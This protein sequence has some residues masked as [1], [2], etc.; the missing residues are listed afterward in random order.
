MPYLCLLA[1][2]LDV[3]PALLV[4]AVVCAVR[5]PGLAGPEEVQDLDPVCEPLVR[6]GVEVVRVGRDV[7]DERQPFRVRRPVREVR[8]QQP[9]VASWWVA[10]VVQEKVRVSDGTRGYF[11]AHNKTSTSR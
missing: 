11:S 10:V 2:T 9:L 3:P 5:V 1:A 8:V 7:V 4:I 6:H